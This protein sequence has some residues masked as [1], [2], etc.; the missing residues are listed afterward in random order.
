MVA[1]NVTGLFSAVRQH[2]PL[3]P[4]PKNH[5]SRHWKDN[6]RDLPSVW[7]GC[8]DESC[9]LSIMGVCLFCS[10]VD[11]TI[12]KS[13]SILLYSFL[14]HLK[15][16]GTKTVS[17][18]G[19]GNGGWVWKGNSGQGLVFLKVGGAVCQGSKEAGGMGKRSE[20]CHP[21]GLPGFF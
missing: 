18:R 11:V 6:V 20:A 15:R 14:K 2:C 4:A 9:L 21:G 5:A 12:V 13:E 3:A 16:A 1:V 7:H 8:W 19:D 17:S 10:L